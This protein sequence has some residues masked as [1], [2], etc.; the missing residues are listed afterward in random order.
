[1]GLQLCLANIF[2]AMNL[3]ASSRNLQAH[4]KKLDTLNWFLKVLP[5][6]MIEWERMQSMDLQTLTLHIGSMDQL[7]NVMKRWQSYV[8]VVC[9][10]CLQHR[11]RIVELS[12]DPDTDAKVILLSAASIMAEY[13]LRVI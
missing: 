1:M 7:R 2:K 11:H 3:K 12:I 10:S 4:F 8:T 6:E 5:T 9:T 13:Y